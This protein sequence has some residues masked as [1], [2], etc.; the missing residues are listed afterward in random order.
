MKEAM[1]ILATLGRRWWFRPA[2]AEPVPT[3]RWA[4]AP[5]R[6]VHMKPLARA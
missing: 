4:T 3:A 1:L 2:G 6:G 5:R